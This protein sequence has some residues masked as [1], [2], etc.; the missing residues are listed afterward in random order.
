MRG[1]AGV[2]RRRHLGER[3]AAF[4]DGQLSAVEA[5]AVDQHL[6]R[7]AACS[8]AVRAQR[9]LKWRMSGLA[10]PLS[11]PPWL[12][13]RLTGLGERPEPVPHA[14]AASSAGAHAHEWEER[15]RRFAPTVLAAGGMSVLAALG[16]YAVAP[17]PVSTAGSP[18]PAGPV[19]AS[20]A[21]PA[22]RTVIGTEPPT[23]QVAAPVTQQVAAPVTPHV[24]APL[25][26]PVTVTRWVASPPVASPVRLTPVWVATGAALS[27]SSR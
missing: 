14:P 3:T 27:W 6:E 5:T 20:S 18:F 4:V 22:I 9:A 26:P 24:P 23:Q 2:H 11:P 1:T 15:R 13:G 7:C 25:R 12:V 8:A 17:G 16:A 10:A 19:S 21:P